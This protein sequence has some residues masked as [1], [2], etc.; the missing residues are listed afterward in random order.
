MKDYSEHSQSL[1]ILA[2]VLPPQKAKRCF[3]RLIS[4]KDLKRATVYFSY[5]LFGCYFKFDRGD[6]FLEK[7][8]LW[9]DYLA[10][11]LSTTQEAPDTVD[12]ES[13]SD[14]HAWGA[15]PIWF[16]QTGLAGIRSAA[17]FFEKVSVEPSPG[18]LSELKAKQPHPKGFVE[19]DL[20][21]DGDKASG[22]VK[23]P[24]EGVFVYRGF[25]QV[26]KIGENFIGK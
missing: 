1:A 4:E 20:R 12:R 5:Y 2:D 7:L 22:T 21:F 9:R 8:D 23:T 17:P 16:S 10:K 18:H 3:E 14:C 24:V 15:H 25:R 11:G 13:R 19:V 6:L 26:L